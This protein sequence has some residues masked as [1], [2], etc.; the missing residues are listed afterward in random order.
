MTDLHAGNV[1]EFHEGACR[2]ISAGG[3]EIGIRSWGGELFAYENR[4]LHQ[5][6]PV[7][8]GVIVGQVEEVIG[9]GGELS[10]R[11]F[12]DSFPHLVCP[13]HAFEYDLRTGELIADRTRALRRYEVVVRDGEVYL[14]A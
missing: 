14:R 4:C 10:E 9:E 12:D 1:S 3:R 2:L 8:E 5:G 13:W 7:C 6:G 11:R